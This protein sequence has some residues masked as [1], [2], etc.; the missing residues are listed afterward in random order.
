MANPR[1]F[2]DKDAQSVEQ[3]RS[4][5]DSIGGGVAGAALTEGERVYARSQGYIT[6]NTAR[7]VGPR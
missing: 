5:N 1:G 6:T 3:L 7:R 2:T 4:F